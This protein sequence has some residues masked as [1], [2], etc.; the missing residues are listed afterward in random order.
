MTNLTEYQKEKKE[1]C[2]DN[3]ELNKDEC[4]KKISSLLEDYASNPETIDKANKL[5]YW[6]KDYHSYL[7]RENNF[8]PFYLKKYKRGEIIKA[9]LG[10]NID[11]ELG[12]LHYCVILDN[13]NSK[14]FH[15]L[16]VIPLTSIK[17]NKQYNFPNIILGNEL[18]TC[19]KEKHTKFESL[20]VS[21]ASKV[22][23]DK[24]SNKVP[25][26]IS[27]LHDIMEDLKILGKIE[28][29]LKGMKTGSVA[30]VNQIRT[31]SKMRIHNPRKDKDILSGIKLKNESLDLIDNALMQAFT[32]L[33]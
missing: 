7:S 15:T 2:I 5:S 11:K 1:L 6:L 17:P 29:E 27:E 16:T 21:K 30:N 31:I 10:Y 33:K 24:T 23:V 8:N 12:G 4:I 14:A 22:L 26:N 13:T 19:I 32:K 9:N 3:V 25:R 28:E 20:V 18:Y